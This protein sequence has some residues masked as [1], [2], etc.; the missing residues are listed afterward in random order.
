MRWPPVT[1]TVGM[2]NLLD[3][4]GD[5]AQLGR[6]GER[7]PTCAAPPNKCRPS[8]C[9]RATRSLTKRDCGN[10]RDIRRARR[11]ADNSSAPA[12]IC[13]SRRASSSRSA[14][15][16]ACDRLEPLRHDRAAHLVMAALGAVAHRR[17]GVAGRPCRRRWARIASTLAGA[18]PARGRSLGV[19]AHRVERGQALGGDGGADARPWRRR[20][21]RRPARRRASRRCR[22]A[23]PARRACSAKARPNTSRSRKRRHSALSRISCTYQWPS[24]TSP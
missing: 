18:L 3:G 12:G 1:L 22:C 15:R 2:S 19:G 5:R 17:V 16:T 11:R 21:S 13:G 23:A 24:A 4:V 20:C 7:R 6:A 14:S 10:R 9:W 8:G